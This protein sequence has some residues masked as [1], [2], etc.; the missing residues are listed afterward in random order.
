M[1]LGTVL[2]QLP[3]ERVLPGGQER[4]FVQ[5]RCGT[6]LLTALDCLGAESGELVLLTLGEA[7]ARLCP[8][9]PVDAAVLGVAGNNG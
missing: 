9:L 7:A 2:G 6:T 4:R 1:I 8:E 5:V 3:L